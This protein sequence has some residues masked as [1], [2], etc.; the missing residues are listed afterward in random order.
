MIQSPADRGDSRAL[1]LV[2]PVWLRCVHGNSEYCTRPS[3]LLV[4]ISGGGVG[5][6]VVC[7]WC[8]VRVCVCVCACVVLCVCGVV[9]V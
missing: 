2:L 1:G 8:S 9:C 7:V 5:V 6:C 3:V 4:V